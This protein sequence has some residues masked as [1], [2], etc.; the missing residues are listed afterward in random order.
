MTT[1]AK[2]SDQDALD[3]HMQGSPGKIAILPTKPLKTQ[4]DLSLAYSPGVAVPCLK[5]AE[6]PD[7]AY[8]YTSRGNMVAVISN[9]T[10]VLGIGDIGALASKPVMEGKA[11]LFK[12]F[13]DIDAVDLEIDTADV[14]EFVNCVRFLGPT[15]AGINLE[16]IGAP[17]CFSIEKRLKEAMSIPVFHD[18]QHGT[19]IICGAGVVNALHISG[20]DIKNVKLVI[21][22]AGAAGTACLNLLK[23]LGLPK[24]NVL[25]CDSKGVVHTGRN[26]LNEFKAAFA[27]K[28]DART[29]ADAMK[30]ADVFIGVSKKDA[31]KPDMVKSMAKNAIL[32]AMANP[33]PEIRPEA[34]AEVRKDV[35][36][37]TGR[38]DYPNQVNNVLCFPFIFRGAID[39][40]ARQIT[41]KM[42]IAV[43]HALAELA[44]KPVPAEVEKIYGRKLEFGTQYIIP[45]PFDPRLISEIPPAVAKTAMDEGIAR[46]PI[47]DM[48]AYKKQLEA[49]R[50]R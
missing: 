16:D 18:D 32:F 24:D 39:C 21:N 28:T 7:A 45:T 14:D 4:R 47:K 13:A 17:E 48:A 23:A 42:K 35:I 1:K 25:V 33:D 37:G 2:T 38:S 40:A 31:V 27:A 8:D 34:V 49:R 46:R 19:A 50:P 26:D 41:D 43:S 15:F 12:R 29:L 44:R 20:K 30:G 9:G 3:F 22:G 10:S 6:N 5:I 36:V 11:V